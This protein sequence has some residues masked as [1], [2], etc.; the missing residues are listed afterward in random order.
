MSNRSTYALAA[1]LLF[2]GARPVEAALLNFEFIGALGPS[3][4]SL[5][6]GDGTVVDLSGA[7][8]RITGMTTSDVDLSPSGDGIGQF[9]SQSIFDFGA[10][11]SFASDATTGETYVQ[12]CGPTNLVTCVGLSDSTL[13]NVA[14]DRSFV[15]NL[16]SPVAADADSGGVPI[17][18]N[19]T[20]LF[21]GWV[22]PIVFSNADNETLTLVFS[23][24]PNGGITEFSVTAKAVPTPSSLA[25]VSLGLL[26]AG[27][28][29]RR[30]TH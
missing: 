30:R 28:S 5:T 8:F 4:S 10:L 14:A 6:L 12:D 22:D 17:G 13:F 3:G 29:R 23:G 15:A 25:L 16:V 18:M 27:Y 2:V 24:I 20:P 19:L 26:S 9:A 7:Q 21:T 1:L 11:G